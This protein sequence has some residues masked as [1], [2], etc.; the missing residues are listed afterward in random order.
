MSFTARF[1][2]AVALLVAS[3]APITMRAQVQTTAPATVSDA[4]LKDRIAF[5]F[6]TSE[7]LR[8]YDIKVKV[9]GG[10][11]TL[12]GDVATAA[13][14]ADA[15]QMAKITGVRQVENNIKVSP[16]ADKTLMERTKAGLS[17]TGEKID[18]AWITTKVKWFFLGEDALKD[19]DINVDTKANVVTLR[20]SVMSEAGRTRATTLAKQTEGVTRVIDEL[21]I[22]P[23]AKS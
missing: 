13:Q 8:K 18:D 10:I 22:G 21:R 4:T 20:G 5:R 7:S 14:K 2:L 15:S 23:K 1:G 16:D 17:K 6:D 19:S 3:A 11:A 12:S 9:D